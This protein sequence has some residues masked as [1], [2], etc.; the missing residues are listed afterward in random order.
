MSPKI[1]RARPLK[2]AVGDAHIAAALN[3]NLDCKHLRNAIRGA[4]QVKLG[5]IATLRMGEV[6][7]KKNLTGRGMPVFSADESNR[8]W[9][10]TDN[11][12]L[13]FGKN[14][15]VIGARGTI[16]SVK[17]PAV[18]SFTCTQTTIAASVVQGVSPE[19][20]AYFLQI[21]SFHTI[22]RGSKIP[23]ITIANVAKIS[24]P[25][26]PLSEQRVIA[27][28]LKARMRTAAKIRA[29]AQSSAGR[30][31][32]ASE[33][34]VA[35][36]VFGVM[37][38][39][40]NGGNIRQTIKTLCDIVRR[41]RHKGA[42][43][44]IAELTWI[45]FLRM[46]DNREEREAK[47]AKATRGGEFSPSLSAPYRWRDWAAPESKMRKELKRQWP[48]DKVCAGG[49]V[50][51]FEKNAGKREHS[52]TGDWA[53]HRRSGRAAGDGDRRFFGHSGQDSSV[54]GVGL[55]CAA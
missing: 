6:L 1:Q 14:T 49:L 10:L 32:R 13:S 22:A 23:M 15:I 19:F 28:T 40:G 45:L 18:A 38:A 44:Y 9:G 50:S 47:R 37:S 17:L 55:G 16:G 51:A 26:P 20:V 21:N 30:R 8:P 2:S 39:S 41:G 34:V 42:R 54:A 29:V 53:N 31:R 48:P 3:G 4:A 27:R 35:P 33:R 7:I 43:N 46:L 5:E 12:R 24:I 36:R 11:A 25:L 52:P